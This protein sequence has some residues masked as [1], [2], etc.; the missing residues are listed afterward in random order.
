MKQIVSYNICERALAFLFVHARGILTVLAVLAF[1]GMADVT[2][3]Q[4]TDFFTT[5]ENEVT[6]LKG[7]V[8]SFLGIALGVLMVFLGWRYLKRAKGAA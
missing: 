3:A 1:F 2:M 6:A 8:L 4:T 5:A 7:K